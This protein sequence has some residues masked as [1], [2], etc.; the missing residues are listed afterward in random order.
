MDRLG[1]AG[2]STGAF[3]YRLGPGDG[4]LSL[5]TKRTGAAAKAG[6]N[7]LIEVTSWEATIE[8]GERTSIVLEADGGSLRVREGT[9]GMQALQDEDRENIRQTIDDEVLMGEK[10]SFRSTEV[11]P[12][13]GAAGFAVQGELTLLGAT[14]PLSFYL[15][16]AG[17]GGLRAA[18]V[19]KQSDW[20]MKPYTGLFGALKVVDEVEVEIEATLPAPQSL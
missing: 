14:R 7:L 11:G 16:I 9:G 15:A 8:L 17:D 13:E 20:G 10:V 5:R 2:V 4:T 19:V 6:H 3:T 18:T 1:S 12:A